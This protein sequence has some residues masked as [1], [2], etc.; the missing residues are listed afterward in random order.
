MEAAEVRRAM[1]SSAQQMG[2]CSVVALMEHVLPECARTAAQLH[3]LAAVTRVMD[4][5]TAARVLEL[6]HVWEIG[7]LE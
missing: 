7:R 5:A 6:A 4:G 3:D 2:V 1:R